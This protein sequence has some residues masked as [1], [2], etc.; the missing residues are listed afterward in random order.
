MLLLYDSNGWPIQSGNTETNNET[1]TNS[2]ILELANDR[3]MEENTVNDHCLE[4]DHE[5]EDGLESTHTSILDGAVTEV[6]RHDVQLEAASFKTKHAKK[7]AKILGPVRNY[8]S[9][10]V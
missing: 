9:L 1:E 6:T 10:I 3:N 2:D 8:R 4:S 7:I 5:H